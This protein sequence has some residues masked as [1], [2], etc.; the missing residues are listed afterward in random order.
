MPTVTFITTEKSKGKRRVAR[1]NITESITHKELIAS[2]SQI[3][4]RPIS[5]LRDSKETTIT[6]DDFRHLDEIPGFIYAVVKESS[7]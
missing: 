5:H 2:L 7:D 1:I 6:L 3:L 4:R